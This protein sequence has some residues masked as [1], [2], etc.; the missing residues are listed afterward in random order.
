MFALHT[1]GLLP[2]SKQT[3]FGDRLL[4]GVA[5]GIAFPASANAVTALGAITAGSGFTNIKTVTLAPSGGTGSGLKAVATSLKAVAATVVNGGTSGYQVNDTI[6]LTNGV[7]LTVA[8]VNTGVVATVTVTTAGAFTVSPAGTNAAGTG[9]VRTLTLVIKPSPQAPVITSSATATAQASAAFSYQITAV[10]GAT[11][12]EVLD[13][14]AWLN[15]YAATGTLTGTPPLPGT[16]TVQ[17]LASNA[18]GASTP[19]PLTLTIAPAANTPVVTS[20]R[21]ATGTLD[22]AFTYQI[23]A[24]NSPTSYA[25]SGLPEGLGFD[26][27]TGLISGTPKASGTF[28]VTLTAANQNGPGASVTLTLTIAPS[29]Q[30]LGGN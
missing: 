22:A 2:G 27:Q 1:I 17:L 5:N 4:M 15:L 18:T 11:A 12:Y 23:A 8:S 28:A 14:P 16:V 24:T 30:L 20:A 21:D 9:P 25:V 3:A 19:Q 26:S 10:N 7:V 29:A 13:A 6:T